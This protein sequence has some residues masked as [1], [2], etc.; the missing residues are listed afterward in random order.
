VRSGLVWV[1]FLFCAF[2]WAFRFGSYFLEFFFFSYSQIFRFFST[3]I[4]LKL[5]LF[6]LVLKARWRNNIQG[7]NESSCGDA[8]G[9]EDGEEVWFC[10]FRSGGGFEIF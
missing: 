5:Y 6:H 3:A 4:V 1:G 7:L 8:G 9:M 2:S 10:R